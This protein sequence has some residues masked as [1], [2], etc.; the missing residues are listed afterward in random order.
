[1]AIIVCPKCKKKH[2]VDLNIT[3]HVRITVPLRA[4]PAIPTH[5]PIAPLNVARTIDRCTHAN[6]FAKTK[7]ATNIIRMECEIPR[8]HLSPSA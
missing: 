1:M 8:C 3:Q 5:R 2:D 4:H 6:G 7:A